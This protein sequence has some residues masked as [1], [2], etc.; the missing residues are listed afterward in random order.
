[1]LQLRQSK[2]GSTIATKDQII[3]D[4][5]EVR[6]IPDEHGAL[7]GVP[8]ER[9]QIFFAS[10]DIAVYKQVRYVSKKVPRIVHSVCVT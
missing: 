6:P 7:T 3:G 1:M 10:N 4:A 9:D 5:G 2:E 8:R